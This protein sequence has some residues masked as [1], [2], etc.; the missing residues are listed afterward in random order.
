MELSE[1]RKK[2]DKLDEELVRIIAKRIAL[3]PDVANYKKENNIPRYNPERENEVIEEKRKLA[4][5]LNINPDLIED[6]FKRII[7]EAHRIEKEII[8]K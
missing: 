1:I 6:L 7:E 5:E 4:K 2:I 8:G 3:I